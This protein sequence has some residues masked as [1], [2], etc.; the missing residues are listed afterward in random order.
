MEKFCMVETAFDN[1]KELNKVIN[2]LI[3]K[4]L[5]SSAQIVDSKS[6]WLWNNDIEFSDEHLVFIKTKKSLLKEIYNEIRKYHSYDCFEFAVFDLTSVSDDY[7]NW[8][9]NDTK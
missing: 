4:K 8:I 2:L 7:L 5:I 9:D 3:E 6:K 1:E